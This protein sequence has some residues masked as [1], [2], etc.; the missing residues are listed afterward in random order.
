MPFAI[1]QEAN[2]VWSGAPLARLNQQTGALLKH[3]ET[4]PNISGAFVYDNHGSLLAARLD[5]T[6]GQETRETLERAGRWLAQMMAAAESRGGR[7]KEVE[8]RYEQAG[9]LVRDLGNAFEVIKCITTVNWALLRMALNVSAVSFEKDAELQKSLSKI[10]PARTDALEDEPD[11][12]AQRWIRR[13]KMAAPEML[14]T[15]AATV[16]NVIDAMAHFTNLL[17]E[18]FGDH[19]FGRDNLLRIIE[20]RL[21]I[22]TTKQPVLASI[23]VANRKVG[24]S[25]E[26][27]PADLGTLTT[28]WGE[29]IGQMRSAAVENLG[30]KMA[31]TKYRRV[32]QIVSEQHA[33]A[34]K[35]ANLERVLPKA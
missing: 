27:A 26:V 17:I 25:S 6:M 2:K 30:A 20:H 23:Q 15:S 14:P 9:F 32:Y 5:S 34:F 18:Q 21:A 10:A 7:V 12:D 28:G 16:S 29:L 4:D 19:G 35:S 22:L 3:V 1:V 31:D 13:M 33:G 8:L 24:L 11:P